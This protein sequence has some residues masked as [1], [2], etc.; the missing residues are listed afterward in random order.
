MVKFLRQ[1]NQEPPH[2]TPKIQSASHRN[3][4]EM[5]SDFREN[6]RDMQLARLKKLRFRVVD[7]YA[8]VF[9]VRYNSEIGVLLSPT[10]P[11][12]ISLL[13]HHELPLKYSCLTLGGSSP[14][15][16]L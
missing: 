8:A 15:R 3:R 1:R 14:N 7:V 6:P 4:P 12:K 16:T 9:R 5:L 10:L 13:L 2:P 11:C